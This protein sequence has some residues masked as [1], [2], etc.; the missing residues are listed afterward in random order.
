MFPIYEKGH[1][2]ITSGGVLSK[3]FRFRMILKVVMA[4]LALLRWVDIVHAVGFFC[5]DVAYDL[6]DII[7]PLFMKD[8]K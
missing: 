2:K 3:F 1:E 7:W 6:T 5:F 4:T 8:V